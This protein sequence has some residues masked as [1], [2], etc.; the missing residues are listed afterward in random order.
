MA[1]KWYGEWMCVCV[2]MR[3]IVS[4]RRL[5]YCANSASRCDDVAVKEHAL[6]LYVRL[7][8]CERVCVCLLLM[9]FYCLYIAL[10]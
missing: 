9:L 1:R 4:V 5:A 3:R 10:V 6:A 8:I 7:F 2:R